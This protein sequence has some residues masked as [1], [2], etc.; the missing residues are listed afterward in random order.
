MTT[1]ISGTVGVTFPAGGVGNSA[2]AVVGINDTQTLVNKTLTNPTIN[3]TSS[4]ANWKYRISRFDFEGANGDL[5]TYDYV[6]GPIGLQSGAALSTTQ[7][8]Y[9]TT[10]LACTGGTTG[11]QQLVTNVSLALGTSPFCI[12][13]WCYATS[14]TNVTFPGIFDYAISTTSRISIYFSSATTIVVRVNSTSNT[15]TLSTIGISLNTWFHFAVERSSTATNGLKF[16]VNG[17]LAGT[18]T[19]ATPILSTWTLYVGSEQTGLALQGY[20]DDFRLTAAVVYGNTFTP[21]TAALPVAPYVV[22]GMGPVGL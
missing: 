20:L 5:V 13:G 3:G 17:T 21:P 14:F 16:Y 18:Y 6:N 22:Q 15:L 19:F 7:V 8:K 10:S 11:S 1:T 9:G 12:E 4:D 2:S